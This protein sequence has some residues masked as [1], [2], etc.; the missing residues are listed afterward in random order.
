MIPGDEDANAAKSRL[1]RE[2]LYGGGHLAKCLVIGNGAGSTYN[3]RQ[4]NLI[5]FYVVEQKTNDDAC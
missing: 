3:D 4:F 1:R 2:S 5:D